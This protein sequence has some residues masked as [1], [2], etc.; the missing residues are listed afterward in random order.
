MQP[1]FRPAAGLANGHLQS[2][3][4]SSGVRR[5]LTR[6]SSPVLFGEAV[7]EVIETPEGVRL[8]AWL[9][10][11]PTP[12]GVALLFHGWEGHA[13]AS[14]LVETG[15]RLLRHGFTVVRLNFRD[16]GDT[17]DLNEDLFHSCRIQEIV[18]ATE[19]IGRRF[20]GLPLLLAG[21]SLGG[22]FALRVTT[23]AGVPIRKTVAISPVIDPNPTLIA[24]EAA[25][26]IYHAY[27]MRKWKRSL[28]R[29]HEL[30]PHRYEAIWRKR[31][32]LRD[33]TRWM[34]ERYTEYDTM[35][36]YLDG[37]A[38]GGD[39]LAGLRAPTTVITSSDDPVIPI[40]EFH[41][42]DLPDRAQCIVLPHGGHCG[43]IEN[44]RLESWAARQITE[45]FVAAL[46]PATPD[47]NEKLSC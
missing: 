6:R 11:H 42:L 5:M 16:H 25:L 34:V 20:D 36:A 14:Y 33:M 8:E 22:N 19:I 41:G 2:I 31:L 29:K 27:F 39:R 47:N 10:E 46:G 3:L 18:D 23:R 44:W 30:F 45:R 43:F 4:A 7:R 37:Y 9:N 35:E 17:H 1:E 40:D 32:G 26:P 13:N 15:A 24:I 28:R 38:I 21:Y 12:R